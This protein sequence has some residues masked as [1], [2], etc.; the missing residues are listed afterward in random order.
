[1][2]HTYSCFPHSV[3]P[4]AYVIKQYKTKADDR[5]MLTRDARISTTLPFLKVQLMF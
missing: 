1:M 3:A 2:L 5:E 4:K